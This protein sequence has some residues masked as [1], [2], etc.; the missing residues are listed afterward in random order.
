MIDLDA[1]ARSVRGQVIRPADTGYD[2]PARCAPAAATR[3]VRA[4]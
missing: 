3:T 2:G 4:K 1:L